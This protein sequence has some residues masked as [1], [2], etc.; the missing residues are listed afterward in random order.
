M[1]E[2]TALSISKAFI[3]ITP[4]PGAFIERTAGGEWKFNFASL[5]PWVS[6]KRHKRLTGQSPA[7]DNPTQT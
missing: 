2:T 7:R 4:G 5:I 6:P 1:Q 3:K